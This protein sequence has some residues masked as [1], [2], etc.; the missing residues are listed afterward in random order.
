MLNQ[1]IFSFFTGGRSRAIHENSKSWPNWFVL[2]CHLVSP[3]TPGTGS[4]ECIHGIQFGILVLSCHSS[5][6]TGRGAVTVTS[7]V[8]STQPAIT[9]VLPLDLPIFRAPDNPRD[10]S[11]V[12]EETRCFPPREASPRPLEVAW[13]HARAETHDIAPKSPTRAASCDDATGANI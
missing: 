4:T 1:W 2:S 7:A 3:G 6:T 9:R 10:E 5:H 11:G 12:L 13:R 8:L